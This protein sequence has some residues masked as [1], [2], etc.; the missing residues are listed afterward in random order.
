MTGLLVFK[1]PYGNFFLSAGFKIYKYIA[2]FKP[3]VW[4]LQQWIQSCL[5]LDGHML[6]GTS[7]L[8]G[9]FHILIRNFHRKNVWQGILV[10]LNK[11]S[12][13]F[14]TK[15][16]SYA[17]TNRNASLFLWWRCCWH[18]GTMTYLLMYG[19]LTYFNFSRNPHCILDSML[20]NVAG[21]LKP[22]PPV[23]HFF[24]D[25]PGP[26]MSIINFSRVPRIHLNSIALLTLPFIQKGLPGR[27][28]SVFH[29]HSSLHQ[30]CQTLHNSL[31]LRIMWLTDA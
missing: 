10:W 15:F 25:P 17:S 3:N 16:C 8:H 23:L 4:F 7:A 2:S 18:E 14:A 11:I 26:R 30:H 19:R 12:N 21:V 24:L 13:N 22:P 27:S 29:L 6:S 1:P 28:T 5:R 9:K 20:I 31:V